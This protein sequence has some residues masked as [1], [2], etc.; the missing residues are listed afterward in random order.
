METR[1]AAKRRPRD[2][3]AQLAAVAAELFCARGYHE[4]GITEIAAAAGVTGPAL[5]RHFSDKEAIL[6]HVV[7]A[8]IDELIATTQLALRSSHPPLRGTHPPDCGDT[9]APDQVEAALQQLAK[10]SVERRDVS[11][12]WRWERRNLGSAGQREVRRRSAELISGWRVALF[13]VR[14]ELSEADAEMLCWAA[15]S[16]FG[17][18][19]VHTTRIGKRRYAAL[20]IHAARAVLH[21]TLDAEEG[22]AWPAVI[23]TDQPDPGVLRVSRRERLIAEA[24]RLFQERG[25][26]DVS[27][28]DIGSAAGISGPSV[29]RHF[30]SKAAV[31]M[32][33]AHRIAERLELGRAQVAR[34]A[35]SERDALRGLA[36][37]YVETMRTS[38]DL[39][40]VGRQVSA[41]SAAERGELRRVQREYVSEWVRLLCTVRPTLSAAEAR[42]TVHMALTITNDLLRTG[43]VRARPQLHT[44]LVALMS[45]AMGI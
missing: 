5:Y 38:A 12:L 30:P 35:A 28:E 14:P 45:V 9:P 44:E 41:L 7:L 36:S 37:S 4:V 21:I 18:V 31:F 27:M 29:Y 17:S 32:A 43:K 20:L 10:L 26:H 42:V 39:M 33:A 24:G 25:F 13:A 15:L 6:T 34:A 23:S 22:N 11:A 8:G 40:A 16:V 3:K 2:R 19:A 1:P